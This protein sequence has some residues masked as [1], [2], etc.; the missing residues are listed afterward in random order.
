[1][2]LH[3]ISSNSCATDKI[4]SRLHQACFRSLSSEVCIQLFQSLVIKILVN[5]FF[6]FFRLVLLK[7]GQ[8]SFQTLVLVFMS[9]RTR[10]FLKTRQPAVFRGLVF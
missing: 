5:I 6:F 4:Q 1:M 8:F 2:N 9:F 3:T 10:S 7:K